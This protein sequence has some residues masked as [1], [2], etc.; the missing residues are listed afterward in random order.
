MP[1]WALRDGAAGLSVLGVYP[2]T[3][4]AEFGVEYCSAGDDHELRFADRRSAE[5]FLRAARACF[6]RTHDFQPVRSLHAPA[7]PARP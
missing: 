7:T 4:G 6:P 5:Y 3:G 2:S 1:Y